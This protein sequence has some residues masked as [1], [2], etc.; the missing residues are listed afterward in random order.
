M[1]MTGTAVAGIAEH[2]R[3]GNGASPV[4]ARTKSY[5][6]YGQLSYT[7]ADKLTLT[8]GA[9]YTVDDKDYRV[10]FAFNGTLHKL[11]FRLGP[12]QMSAADKKLVQDKNG[13]RD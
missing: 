10:P 2:E 5:A 8:A 9:R 4:R 6:G 13:T 12:L 11:T 7:I 3:A 1:A